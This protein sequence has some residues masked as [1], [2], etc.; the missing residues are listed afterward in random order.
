MK[1]SCR[2]LELSVNIKNSCNLTWIFIFVVHLL[3]CLL[4]L[5]FFSKIVLS[6]A[7]CLLCERYKK[8]LLQFTV[9]SYSFN[10]SFIIHN[11]HS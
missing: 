8:F 1:F 4:S 10:N 11:I 5:V 9:K 7:H 2:S 3:V 6:H